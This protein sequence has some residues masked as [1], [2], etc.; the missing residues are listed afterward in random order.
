MDD[1]VGVRLVER[2]GDFDGVRKGLRDRHGT[3]RKPRRQGLALD[4]TP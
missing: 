2:V 1:A 3:G 4:D